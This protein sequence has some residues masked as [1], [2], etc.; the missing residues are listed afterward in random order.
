M[1]SAPSP[2]WLRCSHEEQHPT[3]CGSCAARLRRASVGVKVLV[4]LLAGVIFSMLPGAEQVREAYCGSS[5][6]LTAKDG[7]CPD[8]LR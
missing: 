4:T 5:G 3:L 1:G 7:M 2:E 6:V 8:W